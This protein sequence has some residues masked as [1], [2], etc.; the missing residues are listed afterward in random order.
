[1]SLRSRRASI[2]AASAALLG[3]PAATAQSA[4]AATGAPPT[5]D[6]RR[7]L[8]LGAGV[9]D[10][11][12]LVVSDLDGDG[13]PDLVA[14]SAGGG[15]GKVSVLRG[16]SAGSFAAPLGSPFALGTAGGVGAVA[17]GDLNGDGRPDV[18]ATIG[19]GTTDDDQLVPLAGDGT[20]NLV[21]G[22]P[23][24]AHEQLAG[25]ALADLDGDGDLDVL[26]ASTTATTAD[27]LGVLEQS[28]SGLALAGSTGATA[29]SLA[30]DVV[31]GDLDGDGTP[32]A[33][34]AS[35]NAG[36]GSAWVATADHLTLTPATTAAPVGADP[37]AVALADVDGDGDLDGLVLDGAAP[38]LTLLRNDG[39]GGLTA[40]GVAVTGLAG[41]TGLATGDLN[42]DGALDVVVT[43][44]TAGTVGVLRGDG[45]GGFGDP[46]WAT[47]GAGARSPVVADLTGDELPDVATADATDGT[48]T[49]LRNTGQ[50]VP[51]AVLTGTAD[52][53]SEVVGRTGAARTVTAVAV[54]PPAPSLRSRVTSGAVPSRTRPSRSPS[55]STSASAAATGSAPTAIGVA[56][57]SDSPEPPATQALPVP[58]LRETT[59]A[60]GVPS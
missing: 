41:G 28:S 26:T 5:F 35:G 33:L 40:T 12:S 1:M 49:L 52:F 38:L 13:R 2:L 17:A 47:A 53:G 59:S 54:R 11:R 32:D 43:D 20:G 44:G 24:T 27:Q 30:T 19:S 45:A 9:T 8:A 46:T 31:A 37:V 42:G 15:T 39:A 57:V 10:P 18:L 55:P 4:L 6:A 25:L 7:T 3:L 56:A 22:A 16:T 23:V 58:A 48:V 36:A 51:E 34:V 21:P 14:G 50:P 60:S 29:T